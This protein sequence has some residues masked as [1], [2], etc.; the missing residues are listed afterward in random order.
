VECHIFEDSKYES[1]SQPLQK[2]E[3]TLMKNFALNTLAV[4]ALTFGLVAV[5]H[6][7]PVNVQTA[8]EI[9]PAM[10]TAALALMSGVVMVLRGRRKA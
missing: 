9:D 3:F 10:G 2:K 1:G 7:A 5:S 6:A 4:L 8:P